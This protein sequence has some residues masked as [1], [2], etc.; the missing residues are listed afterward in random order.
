MGRLS[1]ARIS[2]GPAE[3]AAIYCTP[4]KPEPREVEIGQA[5]QAVYHQYSSA[6]RVPISFIADLNSRP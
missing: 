1:L 6:P 3:G 5:R 4:P 2:A